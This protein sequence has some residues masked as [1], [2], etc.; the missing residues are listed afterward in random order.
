MSMNLH[1]DKAFAASQYQKEREFWKNKLSGE[2]EKTGF[3]TDTTAVDA[4][5]RTGTASISVKFPPPLFQRLDK[6]INNSDSRLHMVLVAGLNILLYK[7]TGKTD[8][9][10]GTPID[11]QETE[12]AFLNTVLTLRNR[13]DEQS[14]VKELLMQIKETIVEADE[15]LNY[16]I[17][18]IPYDLDMEVAEGEFPLFDTALLLK[19]IQDKEY[20]KNIKLNML[21][22]INRTEDYMEIEV[23]Y[24]TALYEK[25]TVEGIVNRYIFVMQE[26]FS[27][28]GS[29]LVEIPLI[30][31]EER[32]NVLM[33]FNNTTEDYP[34]NKSIYQLFE[35]QVQK[36][37]QN[38]AIESP[39]EIFTYK[40]LNDKAN[41]LARVLREKGIRTETVTGIM[42]DTSPHVVIAILAVLKAGGAYLPMGI[43]LPEERVNFLLEDS[44]AKI[45]LTKEKLLE[46]KNIDSP[47]LFV[48][49]DTIYS[50]ETGNLETVTHKNS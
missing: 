25:Q 12:G 1:G 18:T 8:I 4:V 13:L 35:E 15:H 3:P 16:P 48:D 39:D 43:E 34:R 29:K 23:E 24:N 28:V 26:T 36:T 50:G 14:N 22:S 47:A 44:K 31:K 49:D 27:N 11:K 19:N 37:P 10:I 42:L 5:V 6:I 7:Y 41:Q 2:L 20:L 38:I 21:F 45:L 46:D 33:A 40:E 32:E 9:I 17:E 30:S